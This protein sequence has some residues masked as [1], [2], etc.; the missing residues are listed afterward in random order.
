MIAAAATN[1]NM[2]PAARGRGLKQE[3]RLDEVGSGRSP[4]ARG[5]GLKHPHEDGYI[6]PGASASPAAR[7]RGL[8]HF[9]GG[10]TS[11]PYSSPAAR[12]RGL[13]PC[14]QIALRNRGVARRARAWIE[15][16]RE[17]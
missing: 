14:R 10:T 4:A 1:I 9:G 16:G 7:G 12:G 5:R 15:T 8:K 2:S 17:V 3:L 6:P 13:K 11:E